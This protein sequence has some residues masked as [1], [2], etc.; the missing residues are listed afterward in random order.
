MRK[1]FSQPEPPNF[2]NN[3]PTLLRG[4]LP[5][6]PNAWGKI[7]LTTGS[8]EQTEQVSQHTDVEPGPK[9]RRYPWTHAHSLYAMM[10]GFV[11]DTHDLGYDYLP[12]E[13]QR[14]TL[15]LRGLTFIADYNPDILPDLSVSAI[16]DK[17]KASM[18]T[19]M[20]TIA[21][22]L[23][24]G[25][26]CVT[27]STLGLSISILEINTAIHAACA[28]TLYLFFWWNK[29]LDVQEP[30]VCTHADLHPIAAFDTVQRL[31]PRVRFSPVDLDNTEDNDIVDSSTDPGTAVFHPKVQHISL[32]PSKDPKFRSKG[33]LVYH[34]FVFRKNMKLSANGERYEQLTE[35]DFYR[36]KL[37]SQAARRYS[38]RT[39]E[40]CSFFDVRS[41]NRS[42]TMYALVGAD[43][44]K[45]GLNF[46]VVGFLL[47][48][49]FYG[50]VHLIVWNRPFRGR[51]DELLWKSSSITIL[52]SG[53]V[54]MILELAQ[55]FAAINRQIDR[56]VWRFAAKASG[57]ASTVGYCLFAPLYIFARV[58]IIVECFLDVFHLPD[59]AFGT[60]RW[61]QYFPHIG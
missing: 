22:A 57:H 2:V 5:S 6:V 23:W 20:I 49:L 39:G 48:G 33:S 17:S 34:G 28:L 31:Y 27:R 53:I 12:Q 7:G 30:T 41:R 15:T 29:P 47:A 44:P 25:I 58:F 36:F 54:A 59:S 51:T 19:K 61:S 60:P 1:A 43:E 21:Q 18:F 45:P 37:A 11:V 24:F 16:K 40:K 32:K 46:L 4:I 13:R 38:L 56:T 3:L 14:M 42:E 10:G 52:V 50:G 9:M 8:L 55:N 26:Q 35:L